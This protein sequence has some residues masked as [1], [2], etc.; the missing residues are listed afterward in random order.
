MMT[1]VTQRIKEIKQPRGGYINPKMFTA[2]QLGGESLSTDSE[3]ISPQT[4]GLVI[5]YLVR[6]YYEGDIHSAFNIALRGL[7]SEE[8]SKWKV[9]AIILLNDV[10]DGP[11]DSDEVIRAACLLAPYDAIYRAG[12]PAS[13]IAQQAPDQRT[14][15]HIRKMLHRTI[16]YF[17]QSIVRVNLQFPGVKAKF[18]HSGDG[19]LA[20]IDTLYD[21]KVSKNGLTKDQTLQLVIY[22]LL[23]QN[24]DDPFY[25]GIKTVGIY[26]PRLDVAYTLDLNEIDRDTINEIKSD[27]VGVF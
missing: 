15:Q 14:I 26:N 11:Y 13:M 6:Y 7:A 10:I 16:S 5:D 24:C 21:L 18:I 27:V 9:N 22:A 12:I 20:T 17:K 8:D 2:L 4:I 19:D 23:G 25:Q 3:N 1:S